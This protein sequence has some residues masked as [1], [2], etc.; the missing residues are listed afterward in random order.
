MEH[1]KDRTPLFS[2]PCGMEE[3]QEIYFGKPNAAEIIE[4]LNLL[5]E[6][7]R[8]GS[9]GIAELS[10][11]ARTPVVRSVLHDVALDE[12]YFCSMLCR[13]IERLHG[14]ASPLTGGFYLKLVGEPSGRAQLDL[15]DRGQSWV[16]RKIE[17]MLPKLDDDALRADLIDMAARHRRN[18][19]RCNSLI[20]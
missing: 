7:E 4:F 16:V 5:L 15:L 11:K 10:A 3:L 17:D 9:R 2:S 1:D 12:A 20:P 13:H 8:A 6:A 14:M 18:I 19:A